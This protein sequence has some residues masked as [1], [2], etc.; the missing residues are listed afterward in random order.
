MKRIKVYLFFAVLLA[1]CREQ[2]ELPLKESD[3]SLLVVEGTLN[4]GQGPTN[5]LLTRTV[6]V[7]EDLAFKPVLNA[8]LIVEDKNN[9]SVALNEAGN[10]N[11]THV[12]L[13]LI[14]GQEYRLRIRTNENKEYLSD[15]VVVRQTPAIDSVSWKKEN[16]GLTI[17]A[18]THDAS[19]NTRYYKWDYEE[20]WEIKT[21]F[22]AEYKWVGG[23]SIV[24]SPNFNHRCWK[25][26]KSNA[27]TIGSTAQLQSDVVSDAP[28]LL[29]PSGSDKLSV[30]YSILLKQQTL[31]KEAYE[32]LKL[33]KKNTET[34][35]S[36][37][38]PQPSE[39]RGNIK[40]ITKPDEGVIGY[41]TASG[42]SEKRIFVTAQEA[43]WQYE[44]DCSYMRVINDPD[45]INLW[46]P[47]YLPFDAERSR[48][49]T[50]AYYMSLARCV[51]CTKRGGDLN[52]PG[53]W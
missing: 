7:N 53:Y 3:V 9:G 27:I 10:G 5:I 43:D 35:G 32:Y 16:N 31:T 21:Y 17:Y 12:Q 4:A 20:T 15:Y 26:A 30:R 49:T 8:K 1:G 22:T 42:F 14:I 36:I 23:S 50:I 39:L 52:K 29:I 24:P 51:D 13:S 45:S 47:T 28:L 38:D 2:Y 18:N 41:L 11:Y 44:Q 48:G 19:N 33:M 6:K 40:C 25:Y 46:V 37:F 34:M